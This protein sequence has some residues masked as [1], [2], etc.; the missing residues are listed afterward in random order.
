MQSAANVER[1]FAA[2]PIGRR[3]GDAIFLRILP[4]G[5]HSRSFAVPF[6]ADFR[7][8]ALNVLP[9]GLTNVRVMHPAVSN[10]IRM[11]VAFAM[12]FGFATVMPA[13]DCSAPAASRGCGCCKNPSAPSCCSAPENQVPARQPAAPASRVSPGGQP[14]ALADRPAVVIP[15]PAAVNIF[16]E[17]KNGPCAGAAGHSFQSVRCVR[18]V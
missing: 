9:L 8:S 5:V 3:A 2:S 4:I 10:F 16:R 14:L 11:F 15:L 7:I 1:D 6:P 18:M 12:S 13:G 17:G